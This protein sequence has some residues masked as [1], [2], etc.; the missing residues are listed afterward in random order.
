MSKHSAKHVEQAG[1]SLAIIKW[2]AI[3]ALLLVPFSFSDGIADW[4]YLAVAPVTGVLWIAASIYSWRHESPFAGGFAFLIT[5]G[6]YH[7]SDSVYTSELPFGHFLQWVAAFLLVAGFPAIAFR[8]RLLKYC[9]LQ[10]DDGTTSRG[11][12]T[13]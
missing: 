2:L 6:A 11:T 3:I 7:L 4:R 9:G 12:T 8:A 10:K 5:I 13:A 1:I